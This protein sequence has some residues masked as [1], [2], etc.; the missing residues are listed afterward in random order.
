MDSYTAEWHVRRRG[1]DIRRA[2]GDVVARWFGEER[3]ARLIADTLTQLAN[4]GEA[5]DGRVVA[6]VF[7]VARI[8]A[9]PYTVP[10]AVARLRRL[11]END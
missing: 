8:L 2:S 9:E 11:R 1:W 5:I 3:A 4:D 10:R 7:S 6:D